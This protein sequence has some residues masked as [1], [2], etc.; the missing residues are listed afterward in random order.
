MERKEKG[1]Y[2]A[3]PSVKSIIELLK[4]KSRRIIELD[5]DDTIDDYEI[6]NV[7]E[8]PALGWE[9]R[10]GNYEWI[11]DLSCPFG[12][13]GTWLWVKED[14]FVT[15]NKSDN[16][17]TVKYRD[18]T[19][20]IIK[21]TELSDPVLNSI[22]TRKT[23]NKQWVSGRFLPKCFARLWLE[24]VDVKVERLHDITDGDCVLEGIEYQVSQTYGVNWYNYKDYLVNMF[25]FFEDPQA[26]FRSLWESL[27]GEHSWKK[28]PH[29]FVGEFTLLSS[30]GQP[31]T[32]EQEAVNA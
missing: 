29:V 28:N 8:D 17:F 32:K 3:T 9:V 6:G 30:T 12:A 4:T 19:E 23:L 22:W 11:K 1:M 13:P 14:H 21:V 16:T 25:R 24:T 2:F 15:W 26:S 10:C 18:N 27:H 31:A 7:L 20:R 5:I